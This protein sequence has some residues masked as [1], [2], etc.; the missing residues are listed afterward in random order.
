MGAVY[1]ARDIRLDRTVAIKVLSQAE[2]QPAAANQR[3]DQ[4]ARTI[5]SLKHLNICQHLDVGRHDE[6][7]YLVLEFLR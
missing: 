1:R 6:L 3:F 4:E 7:S 5:S 2:A